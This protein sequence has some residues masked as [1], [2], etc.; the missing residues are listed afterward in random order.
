[1]SKHQIKRVIKLIKKKGESK[2]LYEVQSENVVTFNEMRL[3]LRKARNLQENKINSI[4]RKLSMSKDN[5]ISLEQMEF[6]LRSWT[7]I[8]N[9]E[10]N[11]KENPVKTTLFEDFYATMTA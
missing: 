2:T 3:C 4:C 6:W 5:F 7:K 11:E 10:T 1:M 9:D 8:K